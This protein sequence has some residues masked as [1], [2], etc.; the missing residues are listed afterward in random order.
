[1]KYTTVSVCQAPEIL[2]NIDGTLDVIIKNALKAENIGSSLVCFPECYLQGY[3]TDEKNVSKVAIDLH[4][5]DFLR[6]LEKLKNIKPILVFGLIER[7]GTS[8][9]NT[10]VIVKNGKL[11]GSY[12][13]V[14][15]L[16][17]EKFY[18]QGNSFPVFDVD[19]LRF[20]INI[21]YDMCFSDG[22]ALLS[23][24][25][26]DFIVCPAN[27]M[28]PCDI[29]E[30]WKEKHNQ[31]RSKRAIESK[32]WIIFSDVTGKR[33]G[34]IS[35]GPTAVI[36][37]NGDVVKQVKLG[38]EGLEHFDIPLLKYKNNCIL[39]QQPPPPVAILT[40]AEEGVRRKKIG[41]NIYGTNYHMRKTFCKSLQDDGVT[42]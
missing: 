15:L 42:I 28:L 34:Y 39:T 18:T 24:Q 16:G 25:G 4:S 32:S 38:E 30:D 5:L 40:L 9:Y 41:E 35:Y 2:E 11:I 13:K 29:A 27:N 23:E 26:V 10:A 21:C 6:I 17:S 7:A 8:L 19:G 37:P 12:R 36:S 3:L 22:V 20:G 31:I 14:H 1:M 33:D